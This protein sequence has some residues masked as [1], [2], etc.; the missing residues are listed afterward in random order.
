MLAERWSFGILLLIRGNSR[1]KW[2]P[3]NG[4]PNIASQM[5]NSENV[6]LFKL[7][8]IFSKSLNVTPDSNTQMRSFQMYAGT[9]CSFILMDCPC[10]WWQNSKFPFPS[11]RWEPSGMAWPTRG[12]VECDMAQQR[13]PDVPGGRLRLQIQ[14]S[15]KRLARRWPGWWGRPNLI[16]LQ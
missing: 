6:E 8:T 13:F 1:R 3:S 12:A 14:L 10:I 15:S 2:S 11:H 9:C 7:E 16:G 4:G 5:R